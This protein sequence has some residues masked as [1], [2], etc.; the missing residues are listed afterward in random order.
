MWSFW[1]FVYSFAITV[2]YETPSSCEKQVS[3]T[4][5]AIFSKI[6]GF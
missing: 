2:L 6:K 5:V 1:Y 3:K 4:F